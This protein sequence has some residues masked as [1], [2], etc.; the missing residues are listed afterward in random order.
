MEL[1]T[2]KGLMQQLHSNKAQ[3]TSA[4]DPQIS[5]IN[6]LILESFSNLSNANKVVVIEAYIR[7]EDPIPEGKLVPKEEKS[8][9]KEKLTREHLYELATAVLRSWIVR[10]TVFIFVGIA[11]MMTG[12]WVWSEF[13]QENSC[14][15]KA[16]STF[17][18]MVKIWL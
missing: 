17:K 7:G 3:I 13:G 11:F 12:M 2:F 4:F 1:T 10:G 16:L 18:K 9:D 14:L 15:R 5:I 6:D 8:P